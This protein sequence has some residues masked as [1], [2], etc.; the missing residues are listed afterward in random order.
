[1]GSERDLYSRFVA[2]LKLVLPLTAAGLLASLFLNRPVDDTG[3]EIVF[4]TADIDA[5]GSGLQISNPTFTGTTRS[6][7]RFLFTASVVTPDNAPPTKAEISALQGQIDFENGSSLEVSANTATLDLNEQHLALWK[8]F[9]S[10]Q[11]GPVHAGSVCFG[12]S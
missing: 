8:L 7:D 5:L 6:N 12:P 9:R 10:E 4:T 2:A 3:S 11:Y 1:M